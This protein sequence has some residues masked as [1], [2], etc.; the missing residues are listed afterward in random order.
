[1]NVA[2]CN[3]TPANGT[4]RLSLLEFKKAISVDPQ[5]A[6]ASWND[7]THF[8]YWEGVVCR[9][10]DFRVTSLNLHNR[11]LVGHISASLGNLTFLKDLNLADN[12][13]TGHIPPFLGQLPHLEIIVLS[14]NTLYGSIPTLANCSNLNALLLNGNNL[15]GKFPDLP[16]GIQFLNLESNNLSGT[17][18]SSLANITT[19]QAF[20]CHGNNIEGTIPDEFAKLPELQFLFAGGNHLAGR[21]PHAILNLSTLVELGLEQNNFSSEL[22]LDLGSSFPDLQFLTIVSNHFY[23]HIPPSLANASNLGQ[24]DLSENNFTGVVPRSIGKLRKLYKLNLQFNKLEARNKKD[25]EFVESLGNCTRLEFL[26]LAGNQLE[27]HIPISLSNLSIDLKELYFGL[28]QLLGGLPSG[29]AN[30]QNLNVLSVYE[31]Q[32]TGQIPEWLGNLKSLKVMGLAANKLEGHLPAGMGNL[33]NLIECDFSVNLLHGDIPNGIF[34]IPTITMI[35]FSDNNLDGELPYDVGDSK[36]LRELYLSSNMLSGYIPNTLGNSE[37]LEYIYL[38]H[39][40]LG[41]SIPDTLGNIRG[42]QV[43]NLSHNSLTGSIPPSL[44]NLLYLNQLDLSF[45]NLKGKT[46]TKGIFCN[47]TAMRVNGNLGLCGGPV[48]LHLN[49]CSPVMPLSMS[50]LSSLV[51]WLVISLASIVSLSILIFIWLLWRGNKRTKSVTLPLFGKNYPRVSYNDLARATADFSTSNLISRGRFSFVYKGILFQERITVAIKVFSLETKDAQK[52]F[53][54][55]CNALRNLRHRNLVPVLTAC[56]SIDSKGNDFMAVVY[57]FMPMGDLHALLYSIQNDENTL[58]MGH[59]TLA[60]RLHI[61][62]DVADALEYLHHNNQA[63]IVHCDIK[64][65]NI[66]LDE[67][68]TAHVGD[69]GL[70]RFK[71]DSVALSSID[72]VSTSSI[73]IKG[74]IGYVAPGN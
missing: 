52:S 35:D 44:G 26:S 12:R 72:S 60:Q 20:S 33:Q 8:C 21:F 46:P 63:T 65:S 39:N 41:G 62:V 54:A 2:S 67:S 36:H 17:I 34:K 66:L 50:K 55:E 7:T 1:M 69:F 19:L 27:G 4:D 28:N 49:A 24:L 16:L 40:R 14:N 68:M 71:V 5:Q 47:V 59:I 70:T 74:T 64:P 25:W 6:L 73:A 48:E 43:L 51:K 61:L 10:E 31:N 23:G 9:M 58:T 37:S 30:F 45:N 13:F 22:P 38:Q 29:I 57:E 53:I 32:F 11:H 3:S 15:I 42:L 56:S 18:P